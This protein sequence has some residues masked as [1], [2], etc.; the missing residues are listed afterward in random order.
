MAEVLLNRGAYIT[1]LVEGCKL[2]LQKVFNHFQ[3]WR[4]VSNCRIP[5][6][7]AHSTQLSHFSKSYFTDLAGELVEA[8]MLSRRGREL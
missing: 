2:F 5:I 4:G 3:T 6:R 1:P 8:K 7:A